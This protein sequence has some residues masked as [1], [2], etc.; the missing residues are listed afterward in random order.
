MTTRLI[1]DTK[2]IENNDK[3]VI[4]IYKILLR[5][6]KNEFGSDENFFMTIFSEKSKDITK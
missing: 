2:T 5:I 3:N 4:N 1:D 6:L